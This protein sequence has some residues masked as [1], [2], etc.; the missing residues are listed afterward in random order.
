[1]QEKTFPFGVRT[2]VGLLIKL[3][4]HIIVLQTGKAYVYNIDVYNK[5][6]FACIMFDGGSQR[7]YVAF[8]TVGNSVKDIE[9]FK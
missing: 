1:M 2:V 6:F 7:R 9:L 5:M 3:L 4:V 8:G